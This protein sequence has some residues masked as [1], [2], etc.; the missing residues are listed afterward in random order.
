MKHLLEPLA[1]QFQILGDY[2]CIAVAD[3]YPY[4]LEFCFFPKHMGFLLLPK[5]C[6][7]W[8]A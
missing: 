5:G 4:P 1:S 3:S 8:A 7:H 6:T 2:S